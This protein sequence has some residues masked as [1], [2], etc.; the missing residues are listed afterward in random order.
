MPAAR[1]RRK[2]RERSTNDPVRFRRT[3][4]MHRSAL[5][6]SALALVA[7]AAAVPGGA[8]AAGKQIV[9][10][11]NRV[12]GGD[13]ELYSVAPDGTGLERLTNHP[14]PE[15]NPATP[16]TGRRTP[17]AKTAAA[18]G[19]AS[20]FRTAAA[21]LQTPGTKPTGKGTGQ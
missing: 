4:A 20:W 1:G 21:T 9:F 14:G 18:Q 6:R 5:V 17:W 7:V 11:S 3:S 2:A 15:T 8:Q 12:A 10:Q 19:T 13:T 16:P